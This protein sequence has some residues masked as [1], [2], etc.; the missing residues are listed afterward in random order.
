MHS[1]LPMPHPTTRLAQPHP[2]QPMQPMQPALGHTHVWVE[3]GQEQGGAEVHELHIHVHQERQAP[4]ADAPLPSSPH[5]NSGQPLLSLSHLHQQMALG[6]STSEHLERPTPSSNTP[7]PI[8]GQP[9]LMSQHTLLHPENQP[10]ARQQ[11]HGSQ[12]QD[13]APAPNSPAVLQSQGREWPSV[14]SQFQCGE[15]PSV[16]FQP[17][18]GGWAPA[19]QGPPSSSKYGSW[20]PPASPALIPPGAPPSQRQQQQQHMAGSGSY[21]LPSSTVPSPAQ[22]SAPAPNSAGGRGTQ[23]SQAQGS[24]LDQAGQ[25]WEVGLAVHS[26]IPLCL[27][28]K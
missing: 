8:Q 11:Q 18:G 23:A 22:T 24:I 16:A 5:H 15:W 7:T 13:V 9:P 2:M 14:A 12:P 27:C 21:S 17:Q 1:P 25:T 10:S 19:S 26:P 4:P 6:P 28:H 3:P 20:G